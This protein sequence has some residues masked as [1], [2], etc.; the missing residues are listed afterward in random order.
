MSTA[1][2]MNSISYTKDIGLRKAQKEAEIIEKP[3]GEKQRYAQRLGATED[4]GIII[5][6]LPQIIQ[7]YLKN[8]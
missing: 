3:N 7:R 1:V 4:R 8:K 2:G 5:S 6:H